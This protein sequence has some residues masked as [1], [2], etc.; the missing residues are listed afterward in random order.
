M[1][2][3]TEIFLLDLSVDRDE[4]SSNV[5]DLQDKEEETTDQPVQWRLT[6]MENDNDNN[7]LKPPK[8]KLKLTK[9]SKTSSE[10]NTKK[11]RQTSRHTVESIIDMKILPSSAVR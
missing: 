9:L 10:A 8:G 4:N 3:E 11:R 1:I 7:N 5:S 6:P 2:I